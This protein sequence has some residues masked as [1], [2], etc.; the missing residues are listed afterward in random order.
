MGQFPTWEKAAKAGKLFQADASVE[1]SAHH[2]PPMK[3]SKRQHLL[4]LSGGFL[5]ICL[6]ANVVVYAHSNES[7]VAIYPNQTAAAEQL[8]FPRSR[9]SRLNKILGLSQGSSF[10][11]QSIQQNSSTGHIVKA[12]TAT[13]SGKVTDLPGKRNI[14]LARV[15]L[16]KVGEEHKRI[17]VEA[18]EDGGYLFSDIEPGEWRVTVS[19]LDMLSYTKT[20][21]LIAG[22]SK[23]VN[24]S[25]EDL[26]PV[27]VLR[28]TGKRSL[29]HPESIGSRTNLDH[30][31]IQEYR[32]GNDLRSLIESTPGVIA[33]SFGNIITRGEHNA[34]NYELDGVVLPEAAGVLQQSQF[35]SPRSLQNMQV[36]IGGYRAQDGGGPLGAVAHMRS[37]PI[38]SKP[39]LT[40]G[41]QIGGPLAGSIYYNG[42]TAVSQD[43]NSR[44]NRLRIESSG[45]FLGTVLGNAPPLKRFRNNYRSDINTLTKLEYAISPR[46]TINLTCGIN[47]TV[48][49]IPISRISRT[50]GVRQIQRDRANFLILNYKHRFE[51]FFEE[52]NLHLL[53]GFY[54]QRFHSRNV[55]D[56]DPVFNGDQPLQSLQPNA[57]RFNYVFSA[58]GDITKRLFNTH[59]LK[60]GFLSEIRPVRTN[61]NAFYYNNDPNDPDV[62]YAA[63]ISPFT[64]RPGD[65]NF[66][67][68][69]GKYKGFRYLQSAYFQDSFRPTTGFLKRLTLDAGVRF[70]LYHGI[71]GNTLRV[72]Q[73][74]A[75]IPDTPA[76]SIN[77][78]LTQR[79]T[80]AQA[81][82]RYG[83]SFVLTK[84]TVLRGSYS[85]LFTPPPVDVFSTPP[86]L[87][88]LVDGV[89]NGTVRPMRALRGKLIDVSL[90]QQIGPRFVTRTNLFYKKLQNFGDSGVVGNTLLYNRQT[91]DAQEAYGVETRIDLKGS[92]DGY[93][94]NG[95]LSNTIQQAYLRRTRQVNGGIYDIQPVGAL[96]RYPDHD[97]R[98][99]MVAGLGY[100]SRKNWW[101]LSDVQ[102]LTGLQDQRDVALY[103]PHPLRTPPLTLLGLSGGYRLPHHLRAKNPLIP[104]SFDVRVENV[105]NQRLPTNLGSPFQG[106][107]YL[108]PLRVLAGFSWYFGHEDNKATTKTTHTI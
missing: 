71:F 42:S 65:P 59:H 83:A 1:C 60:L 85:D 88:A 63:L 104:S 4:F 30:R 64:G 2:E 76:F 89:F 43:P 19:A 9:V 99:S 34:I 31:F 52:A 20:I 6:Q 70:D 62:P 67:N 49:Q 74:I 18:Q 68:N 14:P 13:L 54:Y 37:L 8:H 57:K 107:R 12:S 39:Q 10:V 41:Q 47:E 53:H 106:T 98:L 40:M 81:S 35:V 16:I 50:A 25:L 87:T 5:I 95:F 55:F 44:L 32:S 78:F 102:V 29:T 26:E 96:L 69:L 82:G 46:D 48:F 36:D 7:S 23:T 92:R 73:T 72:A 79:V 66:V 75:S 3:I 56:P 86:D 21:N 105:L 100:K 28:I 80:D 90:E 38:L 93:G 17:E 91:F 22:E 77:P 24:M 103:G 61:F 58:Q 27:D 11:A 45:S 94:F 97:R 84:N 15:V 33:D 108:L 101:F 51:K